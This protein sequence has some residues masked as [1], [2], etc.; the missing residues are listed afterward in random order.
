MRKLI[1]SAFIA[2]LGYLSASA[3][4]GEHRSDF[5]VGF[6][7]GYVMSNV[8]FQPTVPQGM[9][10]GA[11][12]GLS[13]RY[14]CEK[15]FKTICSVYAEVNYA[16]L[17]WKENIRTEDDLPVYNAAIGANEEYS[18]TLN[19]IQVP[20][21]AHLAWGREVKGLNFYINLGPQFGYMLSE[22]VK[23]NYTLDNV[24]APGTRDANGVAI[25]RSSATLAQDSLPVKYKFDYGI[26]GGI[27]VEYSV[28][29]VG[30]FL[31]EARYYYGLGNIFGNSKRDEFGK[32][33][34]GNVV[35]KLAYLF[36]IA[37][38]KNVTRK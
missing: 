9:H 7:G 12:G 34:Y 22:S 23:T 31:A 8:G 30:H 18:R 25:G 24:I 13:M 3:Q 20:V 16:S 33:N 4:V 2:L 6:N 32:S 11:T 10:G 29:K 15:Y 36:D 28:P 5:A 14:V 21:M 27:G 37:K 38:T 1:L 26:A 35:V 17:G 19:Y